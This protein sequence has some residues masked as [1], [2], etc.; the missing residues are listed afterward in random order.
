MSIELVSTTDTPEQ[1]Q[2][3]LGGLKQ[4]VQET[5]GQKSETAE[6]AVETKDE[7]ETSEKAIEE[8][9]SDEAHEEEDEGEE[10]SEEQENDKPKKKNG[11][12]KRIE[13][14]QKRLEEKDR[15]IEFMR[16]QA[17]KGNAAPEQKEAPKSLDLKKP[18]PDDF[19]S[20]TDYVEALTDYKLSVKDKERQEESAKQKLKEEFEAK[21]KD[22]KSKV[23]EFSK[24]VDDF[25]E[26]IYEVNDI[27]LSY[28]LQEN[29][30]TS[31]LGPQLMYELSKNRKELERINKLN[32]VQVAREIGRLEAKLS[33]KDQSQQEIKK[34]SAP[35]APAPIS[36]IGTKGSTKTFKAVEDMSLSE[37]E[38]YRKTK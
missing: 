11:F 29:I 33:Q 4:V 26:A 30:L 28:D 21:T 17:L 15:E 18:I 3:A 32:P 38:Q 7:S 36:P 6:K 14:F 10:E 34:V 16:Q 19:D 25:E 22:F 2:A 24:H 23:E 20:H 12:K 31:D 35:K 8:K 1:V 37:Y 5:E 9:E 27:P 13:R